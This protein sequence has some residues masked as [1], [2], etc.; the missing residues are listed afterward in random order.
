MK[1]KIII[2]LTFLATVGLMGNSFANRTD[3]GSYITGNGYAHQPVY[4]VIPKERPALLKI[5]GVWAKSINKTSAN[6]MVPM[7]MVTYRKELSGT[8]QTN[9]G[10]VK[11]INSNNNVFVIENKHCPMTTIVSTD[12]D[13]ISSLHLG[14]VVSVK[15]NLGSNRAVSVN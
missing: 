4:S 2:M 13:T 10:I 5:G 8:S 1:N 11:A 7:G 14:Q 12:S 6:T 9:M 15:L 3:S